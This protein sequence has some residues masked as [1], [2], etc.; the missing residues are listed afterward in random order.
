MRF[1][2]RTDAGRRLASE[3][4]RYR[5]QH[6]VVLALPRGGVPVAAEIAQALAAPLDLVLVRKIGLPWQ[7]ELAL[8]AVVVD[9]GEPIIVRNEAF[10]RLA[11][12]DEDEFQRICRREL[13]EIDHRRACY[14]G[15]RARA[16]LA[17][18]TVIVVDDGVATGATMRAALR[19]IRQRRPRK[20]VLAVP[21]APAGVVA[22]LRAEV[23]DLVCLDSPEPFVAISS[24][25]RDFAQ[26]ADEEVV[27]ILARFPAGERQAGR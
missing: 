6:P 15:L 22:E 8:G 26:V 11:A 5:G 25:Y 21:V 9:G 20:L 1:L 13:A 4:V 18:Q 2:N 17:G 3:L 23:D 10:I 14:L 27:S 16:P 12:I 24:F 7:P 19:A